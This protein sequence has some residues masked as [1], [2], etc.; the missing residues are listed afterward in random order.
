LLKAWTQKIPVNGAVTQNLAKQARAKLVD[1]EKKGAKFLVGGSD[2]KDESTAT[3]APS[4]ITNTT[5]DMDIF[6][7]EAFGPSFSFFVVE[8]QEEALKLVNDSDYGLVGAVHTADMHRGVQLARRME[9][10]IAHVNGSTAYDECKDFYN[11]KP[12][13][14]GKMLIPTFTA[15]LPLG[16]AKNSGWGRT[17]GSW[18]LENFTVL[19]TVAIHMKP[20]LAPW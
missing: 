7:E 14:H 4:I 15:T 20:G 9:V 13:A 19:Q 3:L 12:F 1:A 8:D 11:V 10:G 16:G 17:N 5:P 18:G 2:Y 6:D